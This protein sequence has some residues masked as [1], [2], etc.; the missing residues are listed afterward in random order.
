MLRDPVDDLER[1]VALDRLDDAATQLC[2]SVRIVR[3][4]ERE[5][6]AGSA[7]R[8]RAL[9]DVDCVKNAI[10]PSSRI[11]QIGIE[12][13]DPSGSTVARWTKFRPSMKSASIRGST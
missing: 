8:F 3:V 9:R 12:C 11:A 10:R 5:R 1:G 4:D 6:D 13:G 7:A 2:V